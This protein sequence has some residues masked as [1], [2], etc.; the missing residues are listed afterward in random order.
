MRLI[1]TVND[2]VKGRKLSAFL[3]GQG[4]NNQLEM[5]TNTD[6]GSHAYGEVSGNI[7]V[8]DEDQF[9]KAMRWVEDFEKNPDD[10]RFE[11]G[12]VKPTIIPQVIGAKEPIPLNKG[13]NSIN[14]VYGNR[15]EAL[16]RTAIRL[17]SYGKITMGFLILCCI[18]FLVSELTAPSYTTLP[19]NLPYTPL[20]AAPIKKQFL[21]DYPH[22][23][24][25][26]DTVVKLYGVDKLQTPQDLPPEG[27]YLLEEFHKTPYWEG[28]YDLLVQKIQ[29]KD[30][31]QTHPP[32]FEKISEG[33]YW[34]LFTPCLLHNDILHLL[35]NMIWLIILGK[36]I[37]QRLSPRR[38]ML[39]ILVIGI[40]SNTSQYFMG[41]PNFLG[42]SGIVCGMLTFIWVRQ[43][44]AP[45]EGYPLQHSTIMFL[46]YFVA[47][48]FLI[49][50]GSF[51]LEVEHALSA[52]P[53]IANT[54]HLV[55]GA[56]GALLGCLSF[57]SWRTDKHKGVI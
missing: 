56:L 22:A 42:F 18:I 17:E 29:G 3:S 10:V 21:Y 54:A 5:T 24:E 36:Q 2:A 6:W 39:L 46:V 28:G 40:L 52:S 11:K 34:R 27:Q 13:F 41:G 32:L 37:E 57:F 19:D 9:E 16:N 1:Y 55:G 51:Y 8:Y 47:T 20:T 44:K 7:W 43:H 48:V 25:L 53:G 4:I 23:Y 26:L 30:I 49:Q 14:M 50:L 31:L 45:W 35:F 15:K 33:E 38:Y 12:T